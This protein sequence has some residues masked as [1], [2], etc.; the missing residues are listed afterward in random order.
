MRWA[1]GIPGSGVVSTHSGP[2]PY[3]FPGAMCVPITYGQAVG[4]NSETSSPETA[5]PTNRLWSKHDVASY[6]GVSSIEGLIGRHPEFPGPLPL[7][8]HARR[9]RPQD[10][11]E[12]IDKLC[13][14]SLAG[15][16]S[17]SALHSNQAD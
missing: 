15:V 10:I 9:W 3:F 14:G 16:C 7:N 4:M 13:D 1:P 2:N 6:L 11:V 17:G 8:I 5:P 12:W